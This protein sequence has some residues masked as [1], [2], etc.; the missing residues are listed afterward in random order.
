MDQADRD[1]IIE[2][3]LAVDAAMRKYRIW[4]AAPPNMENYAKL[5]KERLDA[6]YA[7]FDAAI[8]GLRK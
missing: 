7:A 1:N 3:A 2:R 6:A 4:S 8:E 5:D